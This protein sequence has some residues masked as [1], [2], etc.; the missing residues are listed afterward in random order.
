M[1]Q[2]VSGGVVSGQKFDTGK[3]SFSLIPPGTLVQVVKV[4][5]AGAAKYNDDAVT[6]NW[7]KVPNARSRYYDAAQR[8]LEAWWAGER[9]DSEWGSNHL[10]HAVVNLLFLMWFDGRETK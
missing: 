2:P 1:D 9:N 10:A 3:P 8:H 4:L 6:P 5:T 7:Q